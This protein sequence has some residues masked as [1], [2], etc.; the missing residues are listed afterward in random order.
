MHT[1][2]GLIRHLIDDAL[3]SIMYLGCSSCHAQ[4]LLYEALLDCNESAGLMHNACM[5]GNSLSAYD[6][7]WS[8]KPKDKEGRPHTLLRLVQTGKQTAHRHCIV[9]NNHYR[10]CVR[11][12]CTALHSR[13]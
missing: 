13:I 1:G 6:D 10:C 3:K 12:Q 11:S 2:S 4:H 9:T 8:C 5:L 7:A